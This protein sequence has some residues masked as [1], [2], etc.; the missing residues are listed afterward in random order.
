MTDHRYRP[1]L[2]DAY[3]DAIATGALPE[4]YDVDLWRAE[5]DAHEIAE[6]ADRQRDW[7]KENG[8]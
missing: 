7:D 6:A 8:L 4:D 5:R 2:P 1:P 3:I